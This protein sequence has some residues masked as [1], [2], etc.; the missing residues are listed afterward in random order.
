VKKALVL[1]IC[2]VMA[3]MLTEL[4]TVSLVGADTAVNSAAVDR[5]QPYQAKKK[6]V[7]ALLGQPS[8]TVKVGNEELLIYKT[9]KGDPVSGKD[10]CNLLTVAIGWG[11]YVTQVIY[12]KYCE[13]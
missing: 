9:Q 11:D 4:P 1:S 7:I 8:E 13:R 5:L 12:K 2:L 10:T 3:L 6:D